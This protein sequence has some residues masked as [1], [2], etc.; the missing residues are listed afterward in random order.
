[1]FRGLGRS[2]GF[3]GS[4]VQDVPLYTNSSLISILVPLIRIPIKGCSYKGEHPKLFSLFGVHGLRFRVRD[5]G[6]K[7]S[8]TCN[9]Q[10][11]SPDPTPHQTKA[12]KV[13]PGPE[14]S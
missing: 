10:T 12:P 1:M 3:R 6:R 4:G 5:K 14:A 2:L 11:C 8:T 13:P 9:P 7:A